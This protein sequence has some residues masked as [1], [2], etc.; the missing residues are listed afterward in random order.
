MPLKP[1]TNEI[2]ANRANKTTSHS[3]MPP[4][5]ACK[6]AST[7][8]NHDDEPLKIEVGGCSVFEADGP[9]AVSAAV[10]GGEIDVGGAAASGV[11]GGAAGVEAAGG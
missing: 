1:I 9:V 2:K 5:G 4:I 10:P 11:E 6:R 7:S 3:G 8:F